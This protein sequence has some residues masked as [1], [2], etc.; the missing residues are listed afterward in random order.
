MFGFLSSL[1][2]AKTRRS[3]SGRGR[4]AR[5]LALEPLEPRL[6]LSASVIPIGAE[7]QVNTVS[8]AYGDPAVAMGGDGTSVVVW[9]GHVGATGYSGILAQRYDATGA[10]QGSEIQIATAADSAGDPDVAMDADGDFVVVCT[11]YWG[12]SGSP[13]I[14]ARR[15]DASGVPQGDDFIV[16]TTLDGDH[17]NASVAMDDAGNFV[18]AFDADSFW[19]GGNKDVYAR[20]FDAFGVPHGDQF[21]VHAPSG[22]DQRNPALAM[23]ADGD[24]VVAWDH[25]MPYICDPDTGGLPVHHRDLRTAV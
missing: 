4:R 5:R 14:F 13:E 6:L 22:E 3:A 16:N 2:S 24:F 20:R 19:S 17:D 21:L 7:F 1:L 23:D 18:V 8:D 9:A 15:Y 25:A 11:G 12:E 10:P